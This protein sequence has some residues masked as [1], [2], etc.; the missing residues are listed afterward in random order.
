[1]KS[2][3]ISDLTSNIQNK[4]IKEFVTLILSQHEKEFLTVPSS[5]SFHH[6]HKAGNYEHT[7]DVLKIAQVGCDIY[8]VDNDIVNAGAILHDIGKIK[9]YSLKKNRVIHLITDVLK[10][11]FI[12][13]NK[14]LEEAFEENPIISQYQFD[15][16]QH[17]LIS[18][19]GPVRNGFG[20][21]VDPN[22]PEAILVYQA[23][24][25]DACLSNI[26]DTNLIFR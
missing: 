1:M 4:N 10:G 8:N 26:N 14:I 23:D 12:L 16:I 2:N 25:M 17:I 7:R 15:E 3:P 20:S 19:H 6:A 13:G 9:C 5:S 21:I 24:T 22:T 11:H 18:H